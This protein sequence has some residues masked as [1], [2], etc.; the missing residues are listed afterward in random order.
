MA[1]SSSSKSKEGGLKYT[2][3]GRGGRDLVAYGLVVITALTFLLVYKV[4]FTD[5]LNNRLSIFR[6]DASHLRR[7]AGGAAAQCTWQTGGPV[8]YLLHT[9][10]G[11]N[12]DAGHWFHMAENFMA[13]HSLL[14]AQ[15]LQTANA[16][17]V[18]YAFDEAAFTKALN[19]VTK[20]MVLLGTTATLADAAAHVR[21]AG[22]SSSAG[23]GR[24]LKGKKSKRERRVAALGANAYYDNTAATISIAN[25]IYTH[26]GKDVTTALSS[27]AHGDTVLLTAAE[28]F[29]SPDA[30]L[31][32]LTP[33]VPTALRL[34]PEQRQPLAEQVC[35]KF[36]ASVGGVWPT[37]QRGHW[38]PAD[39]DIIA[40]RNKIRS[41]CPAD[42][43]LLRKHDKSKRYKLV[44]YQR[45]LSRKLA[46]EREALQLIH[47]HLSAELWEV[48]V[49]MHR[50]DRSPCELAHLLNNVDV[51]LTPHGFQSMLLLF[52][53]RP[54][55]LF[56]IFPYRYFKRGYG[57][58]GAE[59]GVHH[60]GVMSPPLVWYSRY[61]LHLASTKWCM[62][63]KTC[64]GYARSSDVWLTPFGASRLADAASGHLAALAVQ[65]SAYVAFRNSSAA[66]PR[67][68]PDRDFLY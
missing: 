31:Q 61:I 41:L 21:P 23:T 50:R 24:R 4:F 67:A 52:L 35:A 42:E 25:A 60:Y 56:E 48:E 55:L 58:F 13:Q 18:V 8:V 11:V 59:Y 45:D 62:N 54:A 53:P 10:L 34:L 17:V 30:V 64:R 26:L 32:D 7:V 1:S 46:N 49:L 63:S 38:F 3:V 51:L 20:L 27:L 33:A 28:L 39:G 14:R 47:S 57:P 12:Y 22:N 2:A 29:T 37:P 68:R 6:K 5:P 15:G 65:S 43:A 9:H 19:G 40:F 16:S 66:A 36:V 44:I